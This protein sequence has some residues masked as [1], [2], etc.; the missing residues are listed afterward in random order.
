MARDLCLR[1]KNETEKDE[2]FIRMYPLASGYMRIKNKDYLKKVYNPDGI[3][4]NPD[5]ILINPDAILSNPDGILTLS[6]TF[7]VL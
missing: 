7:V 3:L 1:G 4:T 6:R 2:M 5:G